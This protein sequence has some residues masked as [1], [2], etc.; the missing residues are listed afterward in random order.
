[1]APSC[2]LVWCED[3]T[4]LITY[5]AAGPRLL[6]PPSM[7][8]P[9]SFIFGMSPSQLLHTDRTSAAEGLLPQ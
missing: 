7:V 5:M 4:T 8:S 1:M 6:H 2:V 9:S 3:P